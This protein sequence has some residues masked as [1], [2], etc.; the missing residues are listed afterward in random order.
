M[1]EQPVLQ[2]SHIFDP[3]IGDR[4]SNFFDFFLSRSEG[5]DLG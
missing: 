1:L 4:F 2:Q 5:L 3:G